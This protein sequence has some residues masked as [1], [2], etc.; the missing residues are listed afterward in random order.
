MDIKPILGIGAA[1]GLVGFFILRK[2]QPGEPPPTM[3]MGIS[4]HFYISDNGN[5]VT[6]GQIDLQI[7]DT[8]SFISRTHTDANGDFE[9]DFDILGLLAG[10]YHLSLIDIDTNHG[11]GEDITVVEGQ[12]AYIET[13]VWA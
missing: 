10:D 3:Q 5:P 13:S 12:V 8:H 11:T 7:I 9:F 4:G 1:I 6:N 2:K